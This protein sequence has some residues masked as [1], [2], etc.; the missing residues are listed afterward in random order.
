[1]RLTT[2]STM[3]SAT[4][5]E[6]PEIIVRGS[7]DSGGDYIVVYIHENDKLIR[8]RMSSDIALELGTKLYDVTHIHPH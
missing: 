1:M 6:D 5:G 8:L 7:Q 3:V 4:L 2:G